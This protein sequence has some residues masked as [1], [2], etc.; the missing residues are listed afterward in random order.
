M[1]SRIVLLFGCL[2]VGFVLITWVGSGADLSIGTEVD[3]SAL[4]KTI[5]G[6]VGEDVEIPDDTVQVLQANQ[7]VNRIYRDSGG[8]EISMHSANWSNKEIF[9]ETPHHPEICY[10]GAGWTIQGRRPAKITTAAGDIPIELISFQKDQKWVVTCHWFQVA[11]IYFFSSDGFKT[12]RHRFWGKK[13]WPST[14]KFLLQTLAPTIDAAQERLEGFATL[15]ANE[16]A[17]EH[18]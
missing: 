7:F 2:A 15:I 18:D 3:L 1:N 17:K 14:T 11:D 5:D 12:K 9:S 8:Q 6:W 10:P 16:L 4:P 13:A